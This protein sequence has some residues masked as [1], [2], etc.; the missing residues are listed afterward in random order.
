MSRGRAA[1]TTQQCAPLLSTPCET[2]GRGCGGS[3]GGT[4][5]WRVYL[6]H[7][8]AARGQTTRVLVVWVWCC[9]PAYTRARTNPHT[10]TPAHALPRPAPPSRSGRRERESSGCVEGVCTSPAPPSPPPLSPSAEA[11]PPRSPTKKAP[12]AVVHRRRAKKAHHRVL[13]PHRR[14]VR[15]ALHVPEL[16]RHLP[17]LPPLPP[18]TTSRCLTAHV[19]RPTAAPLAL[20][21]GFVF[22]STARR[23]PNLHHRQPPARSLLL[24]PLLTPSPPRFSLHTSLSLSATPSSSRA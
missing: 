12:G 20:F 2:Q 22:L 5:P 23:H 19:R 15:A 13:S 24:L 10:H 3:E 6:C 16:Q 4:L 11:T 14:V 8:L 1:P 9:A 21:S 7:K 17:F 18:R